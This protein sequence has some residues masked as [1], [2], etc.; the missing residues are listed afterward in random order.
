MGSSNGLLVGV[1]AIGL[2][3]LTGCGGTFHK[4]ELYA[5]YGDDGRATYY[6]ITLQGYGYN[7]EVDYR[8][9]WFDAQ[10][11]EGLFGDV[12]TVA[13]VQS[14]VAKQQR[15]ALDATLDAYMTALKENKT[16]E[17][18]ARKKNYDAALQVIT[19]VAPVGGDAVTT[20]DFSGKKLVLILSNNPDAIIA[21]INGRVQKNQLVDVIKAKLKTAADERQGQSDAEARMLQ[22]QVKDL[23]SALGAIEPKLGTASAD[24]L[25]QGLSSI[26]QQGDS[27]R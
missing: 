18:A 20:L 17:I 11:V 23:L 22:G 15:A 12:G 2:M 4:K 25:S 24:K 16:D 27:I 13:T 1:L 3:S 7:G 6:R 9:G 19:G 14:D 21:A 8:S 5:A 26:V 10:A